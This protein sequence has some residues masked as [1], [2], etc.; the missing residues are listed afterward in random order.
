MF[1]QPSLKPKTLSRSLPAFVR[2]GESKPKTLN[3]KP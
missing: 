2:E 1:S 3:P